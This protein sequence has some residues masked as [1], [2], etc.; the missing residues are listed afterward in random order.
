MKESAVF[1]C[2]VLLVFG[3]AANAGAVA[4]T[5]SDDGTYKRS[6][7][8]DNPI[9]Y[10]LMFEERCSSNEFEGF[11]EFIVSIGLV[12]FIES[13]KPKTKRLDVILVNGSNHLTPVIRGEVG[14]VALGVKHSSTVIG[15]H[16]LNPG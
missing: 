7:E 5:W 4:L 14:S 8:G 6:Y 16:R 3:L 12:G 1:L 11:F 13:S 9:V 10:S 15:F 2:S